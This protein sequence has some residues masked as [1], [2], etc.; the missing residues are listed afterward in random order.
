M[1]FIYYSNKSSLFLNG[2]QTMSCFLDAKVPNNLSQ[3][4]I[5][6]VGDLAFISLELKI[7]PISLKP[8]TQNSVE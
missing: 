4:F 6:G 3:Q 2:N 7:T 5:T 1:I 8:R